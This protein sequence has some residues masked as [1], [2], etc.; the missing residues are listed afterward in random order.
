M[1]GKTAP[2]SFNV[3]LDEVSFPILMAWQ[4]GLASDAALYPHVAA[5]ADCTFAGRS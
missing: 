2:D 1:N 4:S 3:Q 5:A